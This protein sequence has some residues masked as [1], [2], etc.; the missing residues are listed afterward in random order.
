MNTIST[1]FTKYHGN[2]NDF[3]VFDLVNNEDATLF[4]I[5]VDESRALCDRNRGIGGD[6]VIT[7]QNFD[8]QWRMTVINADGSIA[9]NCGNGLRVIAL[10]IAR[11]HKITG[12]ITIEFAHKNYL[13]TVHGDEVAVVMGRASITPIDTW[14]GIPNMI[15]CAKGHIGNDHLVFL[16][17]HALADHDEILSSI[18]KNFTDACD[19]NIG[20]LWQDIEGSWRSRVYERGV[21]FTKA[22]GTGAM[23]AAAFLAER[24][25]VNSDEVVIHQPGGVLKISASERA[26]HGRA[27]DFDIVQEGNAQ[28]VFKGICDLGNY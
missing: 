19:H 5:I 27:V 11:T 17:Q 25:L 23:M 1:A 10:H 16:L 22:C 18:Q 24:G 6:G 26:R 3:I 13:C 15:A 12:A 4:Y 2:G 28:E 8:G 7:V 21:G 9:K 20:F 14:F